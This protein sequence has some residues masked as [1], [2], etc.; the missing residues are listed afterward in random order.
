MKH[1]FFIILLISSKALF[2]QTYTLLEVNSKWNAS[3]TVNI[4]AIK[5][6]NHLVVYLEDQPNSV[7]DKIKSVPVLILYK[8]NTAI[9]QWN[10]DISFKLTVPKEEVIKI[11]QRLEK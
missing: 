11:I 2:S 10:A 6:V 3:N 8:D 9:K 5:G 1:F 4:D 7:K